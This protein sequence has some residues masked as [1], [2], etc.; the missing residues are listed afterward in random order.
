MS[1]ICRFAH[2]IGHG[3]GFANTHA[4]FALVIAS[5]NRYTEGEP[6]A[7]FYDFGNAGNLNDALVK[8]LF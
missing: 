2:G 5:H 4:D 3:V 8:L 6:A 7:A 1:V